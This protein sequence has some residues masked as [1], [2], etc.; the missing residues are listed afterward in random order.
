MMKYP[1]YWLA[2]GI[3]LIVIFLLLQSGVLGPAD[4]LRLPLLTLLI[5]NEFGFFVCAIG[6]LFAVREMK[7]SEP[8]LAKWLTLLG[9]GVLSLSFVL[10]GLRLW[11][12]LN[13]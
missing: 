8:S 5:V 3:G 12:G 11:P 4:E 7:A 1:F 13:N 2:L 10:I 6:L 9:N